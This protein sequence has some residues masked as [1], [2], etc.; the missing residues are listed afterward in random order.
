MNGAAKTELLI[1]SAFLQS[2]LRRAHAADGDKS[3]GA[4]TTLR[5]SEM[6]KE[7]HLAWP[8]FSTAPTSPLHHT[9]IQRRF[10]TEELPVGLV[11]GAGSKAMDG[12]Y[13]QAPGGL[14]QF[15][16]AIM[17]IGVR[18]KHWAACEGEQR[19]AREN[20]GKLR[21]WERD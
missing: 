6:N 2:I 20:R 10:T 3:T 8:Q 18:K 4:I 14:F 9:L 12:D 16:T 13:H 7:N 5:T 15:K 1:V 17:V 19:Q 11:S 21:L